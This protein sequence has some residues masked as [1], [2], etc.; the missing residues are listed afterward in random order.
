VGRWRVRA[1]KIAAEVVDAGLSVCI[2]LTVDPVLREC[3]EG[4]DAG[5]SD[6]W[7]W[8]GELCCSGDESAS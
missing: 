1:D 8:I 3:F 7:G 6:F 2:S 4:V 5:Q